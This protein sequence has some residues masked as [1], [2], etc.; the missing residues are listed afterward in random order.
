ME[1]KVHF[2]A[3]PDKEFSQII[4]EPANAYILTL[5]DNYNW[6]HRQNYKFTV[7][8]IFPEELIKLLSQAEI[9]HFYTEMPINL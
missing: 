3:I 2:L 7:P 5:I 8:R 1:T 4:T 6:N 9:R